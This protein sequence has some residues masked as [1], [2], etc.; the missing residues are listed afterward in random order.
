VNGKKEMRW[1]CFY[2]VQVGRAKTREAANL[3]IGSLVPHRVRRGAGHRAEVG[4][5]EGGT[6]GTTAKISRSQ[7]VK[8]E[9]A[10]ESYHEEKAV[11]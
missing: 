10:R 4:R 2:Q 6:N 5:R 8:R 7:V 1:L 9:R 3:P 11:Q